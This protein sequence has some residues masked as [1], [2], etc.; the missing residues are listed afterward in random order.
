ML[1]ILVE[2]ALRSLLLAGVVQ[3]VVWLL[4]VRQAEV[5]LVTWTI[6]MA[7][8]M[9]MPVLLQFTPLHLPLDPALPGTLIDGAANLLQQPSLQAPPGGAVVELRTQSFLTRLEAAYI[10]VGFGIALR[11]VL[12]VGLSFR[13]LAKAVPVRPEWATG[14]RVR[15]SRDIVGPVTIAHVILLP[16]DVVD[17]SAETR[18]A[19]LAHEQAHVARWDF[20]MLI[21]SQLNRALFWFNPLSWWLH[22]RLVTLTELASDDQAIASTR[23]RLGYAEILLDMGRRSGPLS[24]GPAMARP[25]TL[26]YRIDRILLH[27]ALPQRVSRPQQVLLM[28]GVASLSLVVAS[29]V[30]GTGYD[31]AMTLLARQQDTWDDRAISPAP[32]DADVGDAARQW[33]E[34]PQVPFQEGSSAT[35]VPQFATET[36]VEAQSHPS[37]ASPQSAPLRATETQPRLAAALPPRRPGSRSLTKNASGPSPARAPGRPVQ[38]ASSQGGWSGPGSQALSP[39]ETPSQIA[40]SLDVTSGTGS[41]ADHG[42]PPSLAHQ[43]AYGSP[44]PPPRPGPETYVGSNGGYAPLVRQVA[45]GSLFSPPRPDFE[46]VVGSICTGTVAVGLRSWRTSPGKQPEVVAGQTIPAQAQFFRKD[47]G[48]PWVRFNVFGRLLDLPVRL[49][50]SGMAWTG[51]YGISYTV[52]AAGGNRL[53]GLAA[54]IAGD[55]AKLEFACVKAAPHLLRSYQ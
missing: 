18:Q 14:H 25:S 4:R 19:V 6:V 26:F 50:Q 30:R 38:V 8:S 17:W 10:G 12:G 43:V 52:R 48:T 11:V 44:F 28:A 9:T 49:A 55:S 16:T 5:L 7:A 27:Q 53:A 23:D 47:N 1:G 51:E 39:K 29:L 42:G 32:H 21:V 34:A 45:Y 2:A 13:L 37:F 35:T 33:G 46:A 15:I 20:A 3:S 36:E 40:G 54:L 24:R 31:P 22:R 41:P